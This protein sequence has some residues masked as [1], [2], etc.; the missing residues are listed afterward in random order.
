MPV[1]CHMRTMSLAPL[2]GAIASIYAGHVCWLH[3]KVRAPARGLV[4]DARVSA[5]LILCYTGWMSV[6][7]LMGAI[8]LIDADHAHWRPFKVRPQRMAL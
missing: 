5:L 2:M 1:P 4:K 7:P 8:A 3:V 6:A